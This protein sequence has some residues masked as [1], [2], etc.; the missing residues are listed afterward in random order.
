MNEKTYDKISIRDAITILFGYG[1]PDDIKERLSGL[2]GVDLFDAEL[3][4]TKAAC[5][6]ACTIMEKYLEEHGEEE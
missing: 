4:L 1:V 5:K 3:Q 2:S 6:K